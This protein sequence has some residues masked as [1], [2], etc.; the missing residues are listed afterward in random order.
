MSASGGCIPRCCI[1]DLYT[2]NTLGNRVKLIEE[3][4][5]AWNTGVAGKVGICAS[6]DIGGR[7]M[8]KD[9]TFT[10]FMIVWYAYVNNLCCIHTRVYARYVT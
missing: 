3:E 8:P 5:T 9:M 4:C 10:S 2:G 7:V 6:D 1:L